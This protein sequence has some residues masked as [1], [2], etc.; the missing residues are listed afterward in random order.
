MQEA[1][2]FCVSICCWLWKFPSFSPCTLDTPKASSGR[3]CPSNAFCSAKRIIWSSKWTREMTG[4]FERRSFP[5]PNCSCTVS[6]SRCT[7]CKAEKMMIHSLCAC[8]CHSLS[9]DVVSFSFS[10]PLGFHNHGNGPRLLELPPSPP[11]FA[12]RKAWGSTKEPTLREA[13]GLTLQ[14]SSTSFPPAHLLQ[15]HST[16][17]GGQ[18]KVFQSWSGDTG[19][20]VEGNEFHPWSCSFEKH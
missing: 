14:L 2:P 3:H 5:G 18:R 11:Q 1:T 12:S 19:N 15:L 20:T 16:K 9:S 4:A 8:P 13:Q 6:W 10:K 17:W 7:S